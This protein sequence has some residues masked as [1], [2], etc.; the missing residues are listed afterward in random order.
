MNA[1]TAYRLLGVMLLLAIGVER[2]ASGHRSPNVARYQEQIRRAAEHVPICIGAWVGQDT[3]VPAQA[4][5]VLKP[6]VMISRVYTNVENGLTAGVMLVHCSDAHSMVGHFP[7]RCYPADGWA[8]QSSTPRDWT[9][10]DLKLAGTEYQFSMQPAGAA[11]KTIVVANCL[12]RPDHRVLRNMQ[13]LSDTLSGAD[14]TSSGAGQIQVYFQCD[15]PP[16]Q[17][18]R[19]ITELLRGFR[20]VLDAILSTPGQ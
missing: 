18:E 7:L 11:P 15:I 6:N 12:L 10:D 16:E 2:Y 3:H 4:L 17:R 19:A 14:G 1:N 8:V 9:V 13:E 5:T 20:P